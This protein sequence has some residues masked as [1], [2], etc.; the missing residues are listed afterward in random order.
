MKSKLRIFLAFSLATMVFGSGCSKCKQETAPARPLPASLGT[1]GPVVAGAFYPGGPAELK[2]MVQ[3]YLDQASAPELSGKL[4]GVMSPHAGYIFSGPV[5]AYAYKALATQGKKK[6]VIIAPSHH[7]PAR[8]WSRC[9]MPTITRP[10]WA[11][12]RSPGTRSRSFIP[13]ATG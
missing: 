4:F 8:V 6:F 13:K 3:S 1:Y 2:E 10:R 7:Y 11:R 5:A 9:S 12:S